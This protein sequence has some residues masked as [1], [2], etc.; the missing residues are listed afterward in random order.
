MISWFWLAITASALW[1]MTYV[2]SQYLLGFLNPVQLM[3]TSSLIICL[4]LS[5]TLYITG[6]WQATLH[7]FSDPKLLSMVLA[8]AVLYFLAS[9][10]ILKSIN[11][12][13]ASL[14]AVIES[15][16]PLFTIVFAYLFLRQIQFSWGM[17]V[18]MSFIVSGIAI[19]HVCSVSRAP[20]F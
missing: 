12:G 5:V 4:G 16:Y 7:K 2:V 10:L 8:Y 18:G 3:W 17:L 13:D 11:L 6:Q 14:A 19:I 15:S 20:P 9:A 1:G